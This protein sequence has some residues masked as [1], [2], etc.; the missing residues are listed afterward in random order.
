M[1]ATLHTFYISPG[2]CE[3]SGKPDVS[4]VEIPDGDHHAGDRLDLADG[5][6]LFVDGKRNGVVVCRTRQVHEPMLAKAGGL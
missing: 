1:K 5:R 4:E 3:L 2:G 6:K